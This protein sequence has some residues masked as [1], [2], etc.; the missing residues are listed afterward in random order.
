MLDPLS[1]LGLASN[2]IQLVDFASRLVKKGT[3]IHLRGETVDNAKLQ[4]VTINLIRQ[5]KNITASV[6]RAGLPNTP[7]TQEEQVAKLES[8][9]A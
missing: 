5:S 8:P 2:V 9:P 1:A 4:D 6:G 7:R 3:E